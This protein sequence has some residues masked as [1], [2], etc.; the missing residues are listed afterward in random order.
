MLKERTYGAVKRMILAGTLRPGE[1]L[2]EREPQP[3]AE[4]QPYAAA[5][6]A[7]PAGPGGARREPTASGP[8]C[9]GDRRQER[10]RPL[11]SPRGPGKARRAPGGTAPY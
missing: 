3:P 6:S 1:K 4:G 10:R 9:A 7:E 8:L 2:A 5:R 11:R